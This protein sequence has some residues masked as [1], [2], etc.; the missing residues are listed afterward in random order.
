MLGAQIL[1]HLG[2]GKKYEKYGKMIVSLLVLAQLVEPV[3]L[4]AANSGAVSFTQLLQEYEQQNAAFADRL[5]LLEVKEDRMVWEGL[6]VSVE[7]QLADEAAAL[8]IRIERVTVQDGKLVVEVAS[9]ELKKQIQISCEKLQQLFAETLS[10]E[11]ESMEVKI[12]G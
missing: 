5:K 11:P 4:A 7:E 1:M 9:L 2:P 3:F 6:V 12:N 8:G 10:V